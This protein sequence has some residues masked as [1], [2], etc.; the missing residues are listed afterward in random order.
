MSGMPNAAGPMATLEHA[1]KSLHFSHGTTQKDRIIAEFKHI[2]T[3]RQAPIM[4]LLYSAG[5]ARWAK[6]PGANSTQVG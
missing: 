4:K 2:V 5:R 1:A 6:E 3:N